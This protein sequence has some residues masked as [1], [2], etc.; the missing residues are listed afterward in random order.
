MRLKHKQSGFALLLFMV[1]LIGMGGLVV[2]GYMKGISE[3]VKLNQ[4]QK[5]Q[6]VLEQAKIALLQYAYN[7]PE[8]YGKGP[9][10]LR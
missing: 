5:N 4:F 6:K 9:G 10:R 2:Q 3:E 7:Y 8:I 1:V